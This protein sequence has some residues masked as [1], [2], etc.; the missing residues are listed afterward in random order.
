MKLPYRISD[1]A[2]KLYRAGISYHAFG[3]LK[4]CN[5]AYFDYFKADKIT[6]TQ[7]VEIRKFCPDVQIKGIRSEY[8]PEIKGV[9]IC[10]PKIAWY[11]NK[12]VLT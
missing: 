2:R 8:A 3:T 6:E 1:A 4:V 10:F 11:R 5:T 7:L 12:F 9:A